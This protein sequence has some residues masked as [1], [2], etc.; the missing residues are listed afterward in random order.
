MHQS[1]PKPSL[2]RLACL[3]QFQTACATN[4]QQSGSSNKA[5]KAVAASIEKNALRLAIEAS[6]SASTKKPNKA[7]TKNIKPGGKKAR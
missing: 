1:Y 7:L 3:N 5:N 6:S 2:F 4:H